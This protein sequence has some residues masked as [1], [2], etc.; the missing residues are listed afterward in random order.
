MYEEK[1]QLIDPSWIESGK[2]KL[3]KIP[4]T[5]TAVSPLVNPLPS[6]FF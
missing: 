6:F 5:N 2:V 3:E 1:E 4:K